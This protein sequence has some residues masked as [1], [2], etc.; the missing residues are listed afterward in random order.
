M[1]NGGRKANKI[2]KVRPV[3]PGSTLAVVDM[4][5]NSFRLEI[6]RIE[7]N[8]IFPLDTWRETLRMGAAL[9]HRGELGR[10]AQRRALACL[11]RFAERLR[12]VHPS[13]V[14][15]LATNVFR[16]A[17]NAAPFLRKA[18]AA[19][20]FPIDVISG[21]EEARLIYAGV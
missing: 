15:V 8:Q 14:R 13:A 4:G 10:D 1:P 17:R 16:V 21:Q 12:G 3:A 5:S 6:G 18:E 9:D 20:G 11:A 19:L 2:K 7:G